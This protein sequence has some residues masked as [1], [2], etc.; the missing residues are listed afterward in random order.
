MIGKLNTLEEIEMC[1]ST[2]ELWFLFSLFGPAMVMGMENPYMGWLAEEREQAH[3]NAFRSLIDRDLARVIAEDEIDLDDELTQM[4]QT[5]VNPK[6]SLILQ[7]GG[8]D[9]GDDV[10]RRLVHYNGE[11]I[12]EH[13]ILDDQQHRLTAIK[14]NDALVD[15]V[16]PL[17]GL[18]TSAASQGEQFQIEEEVLFEVRRF[19][20]DGDTQEAQ[21]TLLGAGLDEET[22]CALVQVL[23]NPVANSAAV[24]VVNR[25]EQDRQHVRGLAFLEGEHDLWIMQPFEKNETAHVQFIPSNA[26]ALKERFIS[27][28]P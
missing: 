24:V 12:V 6:H 15:A 17:F 22:A 2:H 3:K 27:I 10:S 20:A 14:D 13:Q 4:I 5:C 25:E 1:F 19:C 8:A 16:T 9:T 23:A 26:K 7:A 28:L 11:H 21:S 18:K